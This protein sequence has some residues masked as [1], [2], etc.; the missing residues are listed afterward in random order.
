MKKSIVYSVLP[1]VALLGLGA[2]PAASGETERPAIA[3][4]C[5]S[6]NDLG[7]SHGACVAYF[8]TRNVVPHDATVCQNEGFQNLLGAANLGQC[9]K[10]L[11]ELRK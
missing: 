1:V 6:H 2:L 10:M 9:V 7:L 3:E 5:A 8:T 11:G 4:Y